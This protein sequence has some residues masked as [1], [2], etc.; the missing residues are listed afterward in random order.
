MPRVVIV[1]DDDASRILVK[2]MLRKQPW[3]IVE[4]NCGEDALEI[5]KDLDPS[6]VLLDNLMPDING[7]EV[8]H[9]LPKERHEVIM[10]TSTDDSGTV[11]RCY[12]EGAHSYLVKPINNKEQLF[13]AIQGGFDKITTRRERRKR[14][15][16][17]KE[18]ADWQYW[19]GMFLSKDPTST[20]GI[21]ALDQMHIQ[22]NQD[23]NYPHLLTMLEEAANESTGDISLPPDLFDHLMGSLRPLAKFS[24]GVGLATRL[25]HR[26]PDLQQYAVQDFI[27]HLREQLGRFKTNVDI[28][29]QVFQTSVTDW[30]FGSDYHVKVDRALLMDA[31]EEVVI[32]ACKYS[33][34]GDDIILAVELTEARIAFSV[35]NSARETTVLPN[36][37]RVIGVPRELEE[38]VFRYFMRFTKFQDPRFQERWPMGLGLP[39]VKRTFTA[40][41]G[42]VSLH[43]E[44][45][46]TG[47][48]PTKRVTFV[49]TIPV[50]EGAAVEAEVVTAVSHDDNIELF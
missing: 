17:L 42:T 26:E 18:Q 13:G 47:S 9:R 38:I 2:G 32:N 6:V 23:V 41:G 49:A 48:T 35:S 24:E 36:G 21:N 8:L 7:E 39:L 19:K 44:I 25:V 29:A 22:F 16:A 50:L 12:A 10:M 33:G 20:G 4:A 45:W 27:K 30:V 1:D 3:D 5:L 15:Q 28:R 34:D 43:N 46:H 31:L 40:H 14:T 11:M 37:D